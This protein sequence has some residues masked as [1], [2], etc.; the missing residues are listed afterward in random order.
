MIPMIGLIC[1]IQ[2]Y[3]DKYPTNIILFFVFT[4][5]VGF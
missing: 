3:K 5:C 4:V 1:A 2:I